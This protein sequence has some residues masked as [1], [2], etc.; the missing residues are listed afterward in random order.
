MYV[1]IADNEILCLYGYPNGTWEVS[2]PDEFVPQRIP[3]PCNGINFARDGGMKRVD[4]I[5][6]VAIHCDC[7]LV[8]VAFFYGGYTG[9][10]RADRFLMSFRLSLLVPLI[11]VT[12]VMCCEL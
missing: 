6:L 7:W 8:A 1:C 2:P 3:E 9:L 10:S 12:S 4:W 5:S 11:F